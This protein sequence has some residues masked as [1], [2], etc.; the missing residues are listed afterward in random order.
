MIYEVTNK[1]ESP[2]G[3]T[4]ADEV[5][6]DS[7]GFDLRFNDGRVYSAN[8]GEHMPEDV[9]MA[10]IEAAFEEATCEDRELIAEAMQ[11]FASKLG[12]QCS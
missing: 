8:Y 11:H 3:E 7:A 5:T 10:I 12:R 9:A 4:W 2:E 6:V 1:P